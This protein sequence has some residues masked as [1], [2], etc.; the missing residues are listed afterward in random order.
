MDTHL[1]IGIDAVAKLNLNWNKV[2]RKLTSEW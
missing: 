1:D 2:S